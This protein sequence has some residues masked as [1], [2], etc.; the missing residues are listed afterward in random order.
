M[1]ASLL[2]DAGA[3]TLGAEFSVE[4]AANAANAVILNNVRVRSDMPSS[5]DSG[6][7]QL[8]TLSVIGGRRVGAAVRGGFTRAATGPATLPLETNVHK[9]QKYRAQPEHRVCPPPRAQPGF[10]PQNGLISYGTS[11]HHIV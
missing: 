5:S 4:H 11:L 10:T 6:R 9:S 8:A 7:A 1:L 3:V 2:R